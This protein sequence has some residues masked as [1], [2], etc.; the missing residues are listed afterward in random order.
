MASDND[1]GS[2]RG[3]HACARVGAASDSANS[4]STTSRCWNSERRERRPPYAQTAPPSA[5]RSLREA[6]PLL[7]ASGAP[8]HARRSCHGPLVPSLLPQEYPKTSTTS[9]VPFISEYRGPGSPNAEGRFR[10]CMAESRANDLSR[11]PFPRVC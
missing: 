1:S 7:S 3:H 9:T 11:S 5:L 8:R 6:V 10:T 2:R 4:T